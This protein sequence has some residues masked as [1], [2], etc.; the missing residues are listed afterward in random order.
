MAA[1]KPLKAVPILPKSKLDIP[2]LNKLNEFFKGSKP[3][4]LTALAESCK[5]PNLSSNFF[6]ELIA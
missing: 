6:N 3:S 4:P 1:P 5:S 2:S